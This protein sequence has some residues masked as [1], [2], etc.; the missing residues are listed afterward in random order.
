MQKAVST[1]PSS[2]IS[3][4]VQLWLILIISAIFY[5]NSLSNQFAMDDTMVL[6]QNN[7]VKQGLNGF[8]DIVTKDGFYG[9]IG[10]VNDL[11]GGRWR[12]LSLL[13]F[14][15]EYQVFEDNPMVYHFTNF[16]L[17]ILCCLVFYKLLQEY[18]F[19][20]N[21]VA[22]FIAALIFTIHPV[23]TE[24]VAN[25]K[26]LDEILSLLFL[27]STLYFSL[28]YID[29]DTKKIN[30][31]KAL[32]CFGLALLSKENGITF[33]FILPL[34]FYFFTDKKGIDRFFYYLPF[35]II[36]VIYLIIRF[37]FFGAGGHPTAILNAPFLLA[38]F[39]QQ[40]A[41]KT[42]ILGKYLFL[43]FIPYPL[44]CDYSYNQIPYVNF[45]SIYVW[46][47]ILI[48]VALFVFAL[49]NIKK[50]NVLAY[51]ILFYLFSISIVSNF[52][53]DIGATMGERFLFQPSIG[54]AICVGLL[55]SAI[56]AI[57]KYRKATWC[58]LGV[59]TIA[60]GCIVIP[61]NADWENEDKLFLHDVK[62]APNSLRTN[63]NAGTQ[64]IA[65]ADADSTDKEANLRQALFY[66]DRASKIYPGLIEPYLNAGVAYQRLGI[67]D[68]AAYE[69]NKARGIEPA[70][71]KLAQ[72]DSFLSLTYLNKGMELA[73]KKNDFAGGISYLQQSIKYKPTADNWCDLGAVYFVMGD[74]K[75]AKT[76]FGTALTIDPNHALAKRGYADA[77]SRI[78]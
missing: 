72:Y 6:T 53:V 68:S 42:L 23:H 32:I 78:K 1:K 44:S 37:G 35:L 52:L 28:K 73:R 18:I 76:A 60:A 31:I 15:T 3:T 65:I 36:G 19:R 17:Y 57:E 41:T 5:V 38:T 9:Y 54:F 56:F 43:L 27:L 61:R 47:V 50:K 40:L 34:S 67:I 71:T 45:S 70:N 74:F 12:P 59:I 29:G 75:E 39:Q 77:S 4:K 30:L 62:S 66:L 49:I 8:G 51:G 14:A 55:L 58:F 20:S 22:A 24:V 33:L 64:Y 10:N 25:V 11:S 69:W 16:I 46:I 63:L 13:V 2:F 7:S 48:Y 26:S 21:T